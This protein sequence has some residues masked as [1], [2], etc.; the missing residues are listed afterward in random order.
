VPPGGAVMVEF[1]L[2][3]PGTYILVDH[4]LARVE[5]GLA[6]HLIAEGADNPDIF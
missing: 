6:G 2:D 5:H 1:T 4:A 3:V